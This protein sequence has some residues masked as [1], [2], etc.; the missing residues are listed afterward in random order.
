MARRKSRAVK[1]DKFHDYGAGGKPQPY[2]P[3]EPGEPHTRS[4]ETFY[5]RGGDVNRTIVVADKKEADGRSRPSRR[6]EDA[7]DWYH[8]HKPNLFTLNLYEGGKWLRAR[9]ETAG[10]NGF[11]ISDMNADKVRGGK[12]ENDSATIGLTALEEVYQSLDH[13]GGPD[14]DEILLKVVCHGLS[15]KE[16]EKAK[17]WR[18]GAGLPVFRIALHR[19]AEFRGLVEPMRIR[20]PK[21]ARIRSV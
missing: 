3:V 20:M 10:R 17:N 1:E 2:C 18:A 7:L 16:F 19:L 12:S 6:I 14:L 13:V 21:L 5:A 8:Y 15:M 4:A 11:K 9:Y